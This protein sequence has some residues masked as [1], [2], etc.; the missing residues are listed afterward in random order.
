MSRRVFPA[1]GDVKRR[2]AH[3]SAL[4]GLTAA[5]TALA[6][7]GIVRVAWSPGH[8]RGTYVRTAFDPSLGLVHLT[9]RHVLKF[10]QCLAGSAGCEDVAVR[11]TINDHGFRGVRDA[12]EPAGSP[13]IVVF[14]DSMIE[15]A[16]VNDEETACHLLEGRL[17]DRYPDV[18]VRNLGLTSAGLV[19]YYLRAQ[20]PAAGRP[21]LVVVAVLGLNDFRN[22]SPTLETFAPMRPH[23]SWVADGRRVH[24]ERAPRNAPS[25]FDGSETLRLFAWLRAPEGPRAPGWFKDAAIYE[26]PQSVETAAAVALGREYLGRL[27]QEAT[28]R[29]SRVMVVYLPWRGQVGCARSSRKRSCARPRGPPGQRSFRSAMPSDA[30]RPRTGRLSGTAVPTPTSRP[31]GTAFWP[32]SW[33]SVSSR[34]SGLGNRWVAGRGL[35]AA[36]ANGDE[37]QAESDDPRPVRHIATDANHSEVR[38][39]RDDIQGETDEPGDLLGGLPSALGHG[40]LLDV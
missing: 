13:L 9:G 6:A 7:E 4:V 37:Q 3:W 10:R 36:D 38:D 35:Q 20:Q 2:A 17:R 25:L 8:P 22:S 39:Q 29:G 31:K 32:P 21:A 30:C 18:E 14:G 11:F 19:H 40:R 23:Y 1:R 28:A 5:A 27:I 33:P 16:Q 26:D 12:R 15:G 34:F 24:F